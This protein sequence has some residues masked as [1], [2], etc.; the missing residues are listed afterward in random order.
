MAS[1]LHK[2]RA[3]LPIILM[4]GYSASLTPERIHAAGVRQLLLKPI[5]IQALAIAVHSALTA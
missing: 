1:V 4:T 3:D 2:I 5:T